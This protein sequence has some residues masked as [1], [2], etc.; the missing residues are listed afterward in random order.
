MNDTDKKID[1]IYREMIRKKTGEERILMGFS[2]FQFSTKILLSSVKEKIPDIDL[3]KYMFL[4]I[5][6]SDFDSL[7]IKKIL[8]SI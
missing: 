4:K 1:D 7:Q 8:N 3:K 6:G 5:Y 2:M